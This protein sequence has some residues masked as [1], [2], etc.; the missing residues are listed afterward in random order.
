[1][2]KLAVICRKIHRYFTLPFVALTL[3]VMVFTRG[4]PINEQLFRF[5]RIFM[6]GLAITGFYLFLY[7]Y[8]VKW[9]RKRNRLDDAQKT[10]VK[11]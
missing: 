3:A 7:P 9:A 1:M 5:Q 11:K 8:Y 2:K 6:L 4:L 10:E